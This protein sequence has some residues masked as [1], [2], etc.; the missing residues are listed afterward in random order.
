VENE[1]DLIMEVFGRKGWGTGSQVNSAQ[2]LYYMFSIEILLEPINLK[3]IH[4][5]QSQ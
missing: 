4:E 1:M 2:I 3:E 5:T